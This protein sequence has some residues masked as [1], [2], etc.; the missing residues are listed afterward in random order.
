M[1]NIDIQIVSFLGAG[2]Q[3]VFS[4]SASNSTATMYLGHFAENQ[5]EHYVSLE[6]VVADHDNDNVE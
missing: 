1:Y 6:Q 4:P 2:G 3:H 5:G